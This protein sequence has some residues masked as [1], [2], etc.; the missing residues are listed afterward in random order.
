MKHLIS[1]LAAAVLLV[2]AAP[3]S[4]QA[5]VSEAA[6]DSAPPEE[7]CE[8][9]AVDED[10]ARHRLSVVREIMLL[11]PGAES[12]GTD[13]QA[14]EES[15]PVI[16]GLGNA[17]DRDCM[18]VKPIKV[19]WNAVAAANKATNLTARTLAASQNLDVDR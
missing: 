9:N 13:L 17:Q 15:E 8:V 12:D 19:K 1:I 4:A 6:P 5:E 7:L 2:I 3:A 14:M 18:R 10:T 11:A 16:Y